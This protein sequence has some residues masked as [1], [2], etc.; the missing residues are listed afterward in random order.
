MAD[1]GDV[2]QKAFFLNG[3]K[4]HAAHCYLTGISSVSSHQDRSQ[5]G[6]TA[7]AFTHQCR[8]A[9]LMEGEVNIM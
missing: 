9:A 5:C 3:G 2:P 8:K 1:V 4:G 7:A 6:F